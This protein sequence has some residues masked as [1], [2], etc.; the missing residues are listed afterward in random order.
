[1]S[2]EKIISK[3]EK[4]L[5][6]AESPNQH[7]ASL[8][9]R[10]AQ[11][12]MEKH[13]IHLDDVE[14]SKYAEHDTDVDFANK[15]PEFVS[16]LISVV[17]EAFGC[18]A[19]MS[20]VLKS[21]P[22]QEYWRNTVRFIGPDTVAKIASYTFIVLYRQLIAARNN[23]LQTEAS[24]W[25]TRKEKIAEGDVFCMGWIHNVKSKVIKFSDPKR[26]EMLN[27]YF[28]QKYSDIETA[29]SQKRDDDLPDFL[30]AK[31]FSRGQESSKDVDLNTPVN[32][33][34]TTKLTSS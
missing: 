5:K 31:A 34:E 12:L 21:T 30:K 17:N 2:I 29:K 20:Q 13:N 1:M 23:Y 3:I 19:I 6:L 22:T 26:T 4:C 24:V 18:E 27:K 33:K 8:A 11:L 10:R 7:E 32:G 14:L 9:L 15:T 25:S 16:Y 28:D